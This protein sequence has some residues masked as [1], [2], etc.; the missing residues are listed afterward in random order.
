MASTIATRF[1]LAAAIFTVLAPTVCAQHS[2]FEMTDQ[3]WT[4]SIDPGLNEDTATIAKARLLLAEGKASQARAVLDPW[5]E[6]NEAKRNQHIAEAY[7]LRGDCLLAERD[8]Y[9][10][11]R[12]YER[13]AKEFAG[14]EYFV[15]ALERELSIAKMY[16]GGLRKKTWGIRIDSGIP[17]AEEICMRIN[18]R[19]A[20]SKLAEDALI[21]MADYYYSKRDLRMAEETY[22]VFLKLFPKSTHRQKAMQRRAYANIAQYKGPHYDA[23]GLVEASFQIEQF[24][25]EFPAEAEKAGMSDALVARL[26]ESAADQRLTT[27]QWYITRGDP[28]AA[29]MT[30]QRLIRAYPRTVAA[31]KAMELCE[32]NGWPT[33]PSAS[34]LR[35]VPASPAGPRP[36][37]DQVPTAE[38]AK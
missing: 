19:L 18:E 15:R 10:A 21:T 9:E 34:P 22:D 25:T 1:V 37:S 11:L 36:A 16:F 28:V 5:I 17:F 13:V 3:G 33:Q 38:G 7:L 29:K 14:S 26:E 24:Q 4:K 35:T 20:G 31:E 27:A 2:T 23:T 30:L 8:E 32:S 12:D 6:A